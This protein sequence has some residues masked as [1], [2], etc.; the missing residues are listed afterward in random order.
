MNPQRLV[1]QSATEWRIEPHG[2]MRVPGIF[3]APEGLLRLMDDAV[4]R[5]V[6]EIAS[7]PGAVEAVYLLPDARCGHGFPQGGVAAF[8]PTQG[9]V[10]VS[11]GIGVDIGW[12]V[13]VLRTGLNTH[14][15]LP[16]WQAL[17]DALHSRIPNGNGLRVLRLTRRGM[18][19]MLRGGARWAVE[20]SYGLT[21]DLERIED[22]GCVAD[23]DPSQVSELAKNRQLEEM[24]T[25]GF[26]HQYLEVQRV[27]QV[28]DHQAARALGLEFDD[29]IIS[30]H[31]GS[32]TLGR[33]TSADHHRRLV[34]A[35]HRSGIALADPHLAC[36]PLTSETGRR[37]LGAMHA[38]VNCAHANRQILTHLTR[39]VLTRLFP[40]ARLEVLYDVSYNACRLETHAVNGQ[41]R[42]VRVHRKGASRT[43][44]PG[45]PDLPAAWRELGQPGLVGSPFDPAFYVTVAAGSEQGRAFGSSCYGVGLEPSSPWRLQVQ[46]RLESLDMRRRLGRLVHGAAAGKT[47]EAAPEIGS[48]LGVIMDAAVQVGLT[49]RVARLKPLIHISS[50]GR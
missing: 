50:A 24:G 42:P 21:A 19:A 45:H 6:I 1:R 3:L 18:D 43:L 7:L 44:G 8:D 28:Y 32:H 34:A 4:Y 49:R 14:Q 36:A 47:A 26:P 17:A 41:P 38:S 10:I 2:A 15:L 25:L 40:E 37:Y 29:I 11:S 48:Y 5:Q 22:G 46:R 31:C 39:R 35:A 13:R 27:A 23:A 33:Q 20:M 9:G 12:G 16:R 30:I